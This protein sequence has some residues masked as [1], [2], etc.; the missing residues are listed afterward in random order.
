M[1]DARSRF[2]VDNLSE[3]GRAVVDAMLADRANRYWQIVDALAEK[4]G[5]QISLSALSRYYNRRFQA[6]LA[7]EKEAARRRR[8]TVEALVSVL[9]ERPDAET[10][11]IVRQLLDAGLVLN[12]GDI[13]A[14][15]PVA[16]MRERRQSQK[17]ELER[18]RLNLQEKR[19]DLERSRA[20]AGTNGDAGGSFIEN[21]ERVIR[22]LQTFPELRDPLAKKQDAI[23]QA[24]SDAAEKET[25]KNSAQA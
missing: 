15:D 2:A 17:L 5:E 20:D 4:T 22:L 6:E 21:A 8:T 3:E 18:F 1:I 9:K 14:A 7:E 16:L 10:E 13:R 11:E 25:K 23:I 19:L 24:L 12:M